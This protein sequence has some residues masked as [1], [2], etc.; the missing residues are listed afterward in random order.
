LNKGLYLAE[1]IES[2]FSS[3]IGHLMTCHKVSIY[4]FLLLVNK[5]MILLRKNI[6]GL[7]D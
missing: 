1:A 5:K 4:T 2:P 7:S 3:F 6:F